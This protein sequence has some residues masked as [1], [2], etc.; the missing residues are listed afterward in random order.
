MV[1]AMFPRSLILIVAAETH[2]DARSVEAELNGRRVRGQVGNRIRA[3]LA[4]RGL[5]PAAV[6]AS[7][8]TVLGAAD[9]RAVA[10]R[11]RGGVF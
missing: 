8:Q 9:A 6:E 4:R 10:T 1:I 11:H 3:N 5:A 7:A 2:A